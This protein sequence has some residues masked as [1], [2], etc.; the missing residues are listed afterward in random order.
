MT[1]H[2]KPKGSYSITSVEGLD[3]IWE[4]AACFPAA[5]DETK[6]A[7]IGNS[8]HEGGLN[9]WRWQNDSQASVPDG[10]YGL[11]QYTPGSGYTNLSFA[12]PN[13]SVTTITGGADPSDGAIQCDVMS[14][15]YL[16]KWVSSCWRTY[17]NYPDTTVPKYPELW[18]Y[19]NAV[20]ARWGS[21]SS[22]SMSQFSQCQDIDAATFIFLACF[23]GPKV[24]NF[25]TRKRTA[26]KIYEILTGQ[27]P[28][29]PPPTP[30]PPTPPEPTP[31]RPIDMITGLCLLNKRKQ[32]R[33]FRI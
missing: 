1:W 16:G 28:P 9:P 20:L 31:P 15:N 27:T 22:I 25:D 4:M 3:N 33:I 30:D 19:R 32:K 26:A 21:G 5:T 18:A 24:P 8:V 17:W 6:A 12:M 11:F 2:A 10:G 23:E 7:I 14:T 29:T 13:F